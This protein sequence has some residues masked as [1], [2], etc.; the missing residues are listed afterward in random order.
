MSFLQFLAL[1]CVAFCSG[2]EPREAGRFAI[3]PRIQPPLSGAA[4]LLGLLLIS[5][6]YFLGI[7]WKRQLVNREALEVG[8]PAP[9]PASDLAAAS[10]L[11]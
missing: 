11:G 3:P 1:R 7:L 5:Y 4:R 8:E 10:G 2:C 6:C 9:A